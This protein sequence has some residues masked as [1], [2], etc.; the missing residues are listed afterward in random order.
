MIFHRHASAALQKQHRG[1]LI[2]FGILATSV[3]LPAAA[4]PLRVGAPNAVGLSGQDPPELELAPA[5]T[6]TDDNILSAKNWEIIKNAMLLTKT[7]DSLQGDFDMTVDDNHSLINF[8]AAKDGFEEDWEA[9]YDGD[10]DVT[11]FGSKGGLCYAAFRSTTF[12]LSDWGDNFDLRHNKM[13]DQCDVPRGFY[14]G[15]E[16]NYSGPLKQKLMSCAN[17]K[18]ASTNG[19]DCIVLTGFSQGGAIAGV[20]T[21]GLSHMKPKMTVV[22]GAI[23]SL[24]ASC[25]DFVDPDRYVMFCNTQRGFPNGIV[26]DIA[27][28]S[29]Q[30][31]TV[32]DNGEWDSLADFGHY[33]ELPPFDN[34][35]GMQYYGRMNGDKVHLGPTLSYRGPE[36]HRIYGDASYPSKIFYLADHR[37][38][39]TTDGFEDGQLCTFDYH[40]KSERCDKPFAYVCRAKMEDNAICA[41]DSHCKSGRCASGV[42]FRCRP[43][44]NVGDG[45]GNSGDCKPGLKCASGGWASWVGGKTCQTEEEAY[46]P[47]GDELS[48][49]LSS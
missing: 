12:S 28:G 6:L 4:Q 26:A 49:Q 3:F 24:Q 2:A 10:D 33:F 20:A 9:W 25:K 41:K 13:E 21:V 37:G 36:P 34:S 29:D 39:V 46:F 31:L 42:V 15:W 45:C 8:G 23:R 30:L 47:V 1:S 7:A 43:L 38:T 11:V 5:Q 14:K 17:E 44:L 32:R 22:F 48:P 19:Q 40:C 35:L 18:C 27:C 16:N